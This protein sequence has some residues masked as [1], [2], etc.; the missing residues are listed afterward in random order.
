M[1]VFCNGLPRLVPK[2]PVHDANV[3][4]QGNETVLSQHTLLVREFEHGLQFC[5]S[6]CLRPGCLFGADGHIGSGNTEDS[7]T[8][9]SLLDKAAF[10]MRLNEHFHIDEFGTSRHV[11]PSVLCPIL[12]V[13]APG[14][15]DRDGE[16]RRQTKSWGKRY[17][18]PFQPIRQ[19]V[20]TQSR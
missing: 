2:D 19:A 9:S 7:K 17:A 8:G 15:C 10:W 16:G 20:H 3:M 1:L 6:E 14:K 13:G 11:P 18:K 5:G 12:R 4:V